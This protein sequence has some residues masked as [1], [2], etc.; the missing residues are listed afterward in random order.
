MPQSYEESLAFL[1]ERINYERRPPSSPDHLRL[2]RMRAL[3][4]ALGNPDRRVPLIHI[5]GTKG[6][7]STAALLAGILRTAGFT[8]GVYTSPHL[9][10]IKERFRVQGENCSCPALAG[11]IERVRSATE[12]IADH[13][14]EP[15]FFE[16]TTAIAL[17]HFAD[18]ECDWGI[19]EVGMGGRLDSTNVIQPRL[20]VITSVGMDHQAVLGDRIEQI[21]AEKAG[22]IKPGVPVVSGLR[23]GE[24]ADVIARVAAHHDV[25]LDRIGDA[26]DLRPVPVPPGQWKAEFDY[27]SRQRGPL[28]G[29]E[30]AMPG[31]HQC[32]NAAIAIAAVDALHHRGELE[33]QPGAFY[34]GLREVRCPARCE[35]FA[36]KPA[37]VLDAAH[38]VDSITALVAT[39]K[40]RLPGR[41]PIVV[42]AT[43]KD[44][45]AAEMM[46]ILQQYG[47]HLVLT[48]YRSNPRV[49]P[50][51]ELLEMV[52]DRENVTVTE[53]AEE[54]IDRARS[55]AAADDAVV[56]CGS[57]FLAAEL[58]PRLEAEARA[59]VV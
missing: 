58:R 57:F 47:R 12:A 10:D 51:A 1:Y 20:C 24:A 30:L 44:K 11:L 34:T 6:K 5:A 56:I 28:P 59:V 55:M 49:R 17:L 45:D 50:A 21:A 33:I 18:C 22:I 41:R 14:G 26:F 8:T 53:S 13:C 48:Q 35:L 38:N 32:R 37:V 3:L 7:G 2:E 36:G 52:A 40:D 54:A 39:L 31:E 19:V 27:S 46:R 43:S 4:D 23:S 42:F 29:I 25:P 9:T 16:M 15:T